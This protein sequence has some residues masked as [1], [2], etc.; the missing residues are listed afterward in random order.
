MKSENN[1]KATLYKIVTVT[2][3]VIM[4]LAMIMT[5]ISIY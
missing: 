3:A 1:S 5:A 4:I 2:L